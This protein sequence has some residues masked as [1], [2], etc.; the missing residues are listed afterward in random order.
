[1]SAFHLEV[2][3][4][5]ETPR[6]FRMQSD[7]AWWESTR[8]SLREVEVELRRP[9]TLALRAH[10]IGRRLLCQGELSG[11]VAL[12]CGRCLEPYPCEFTEPVH[13]LLEPAVVAPG[14]APPEG[15]IDLDP[16]DLEVGR[17]SGDTLDFS[18]VVREIL[19]L[20]WPVQPR[21]GESC[22]GLC[23]RC[24]RNRNLEACDCSER[25][26]SG[27]FASLREMLQARAGS[28]SPKRR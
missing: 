12:I 26:V 28:G 8:A 21:C 2:V 18:P 9:F 3:Q 22:L 17:Y 10:R 5:K 19:A 24:G 23:P 11:S 4:I 27:P 16:E 14:S 15:G 20:A 25:D 1:M 7:V 6:E 13:L